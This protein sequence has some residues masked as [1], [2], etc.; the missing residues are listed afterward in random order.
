MISH[1]QNLAIIAIFVVLLC[2]SNY[3]NKC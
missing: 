2:K 1:V 3:T